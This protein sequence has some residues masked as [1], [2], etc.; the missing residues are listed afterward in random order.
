MDCRGTGFVRTWNSKI[1]G[2]AD[3]GVTSVDPLDGVT[4]ALHA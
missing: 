3:R 2:T 1:R 4:D